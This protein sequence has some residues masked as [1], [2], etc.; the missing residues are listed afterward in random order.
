MTSA[1]LKF[2]TVVIDLD[3]TLVDSVYHHVVAWSSAFHDVGVHIAS[4]T[5]HHAIGM[6][7]DRL[8]AHVAGAATETAV[9]DDVRALHDSYF[10]AGL[11]TVV[12]LDGASD[13][14]NELADRGHQLV[15]ASSSEA[16]LVDELLER[17]ESRSRLDVVVSG[18]DAERSK[19]AADLVDVALSRAGGGAAIV[20]GD[21]VWDVLAADAADLPC[22]GVGSGGIDTAHLS[23][24][25]AVSVYGGPRDLLQQLGESPLGRRA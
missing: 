1:I 12:E 3:G 4:T 10:R 7:G 22:I 2:P 6:G 23:A 21:A 5:I 13:L 25:G 16:D 15:L 19:P 17:V 20:I 18:S 11:R 8:V 14:L 9:G 24:A